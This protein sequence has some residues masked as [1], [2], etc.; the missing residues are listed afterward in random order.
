MSGY[1][2]YFETGG[3]NMSFVIKDNDV[4]DKY[5]EIWDKI[6]KKLNIKFHNML[7]YDEKYIKTKVREFNGGIKSNFLGDGIPNETMHYTCIACIT[8]VNFIMRMKKKNSLQV[9][10]EECKSKIKKT[11]TIKFINTVRIWIRI[12]DWIRLALNNFNVSAHHSWLLLR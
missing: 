6:K 7:V 3:K 12:W 8:T 4:W 5:N 9:S 10:L 2:R 1:I 11:K